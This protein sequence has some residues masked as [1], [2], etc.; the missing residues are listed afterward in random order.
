M[1]RN[2]S[3]SIDG[4]TQIFN[5]NAPMKTL[6]VGRDWVLALMLGLLS[7]SAF[8]QNNA[9]LSWSQEW[10]TPSSKDVTIGWSQS[11]LSLTNGVLIETQL[12]PSFNFNAEN[13]TGFLSVQNGAGLWLYKS[14]GLKVGASVNYMLGRFERFDRRYTALGDVSGAFDAYAWAEWQPIKEAVTAYANY[15]RTM[16]TTYRSYAQIG[17]TLGLPIINSVNAFADLNFNYA[18]QTYLQKYYGVDAHQSTVSARM[19]FALSRG[20]LVNGA[21]LLGLDVVFSKKADLLLG[22]GALKYSKELSLSPLIAKDQ[23]RTL[24]VVWSQKLND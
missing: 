21:S 1:K 12:L 9:S 10:F 3:T 20:G 11:N 23:Q 18:N 14:E 7:L 5:W 6:M 15:A 17:L 2:E 22:A 4:Q 13:K 19:P 24:L 16:D 8:S